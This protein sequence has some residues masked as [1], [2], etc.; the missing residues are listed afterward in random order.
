MMMFVQNLIEVAVVVVMMMKK[1]ISPLWSGGL[2]LLRG[3]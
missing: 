2:A 1:T 3:R